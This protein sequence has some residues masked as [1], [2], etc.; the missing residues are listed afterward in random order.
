[1]ERALKAK[2]TK[3][4]V[5]I[6]VTHY[7][8]ATMAEKHTTVLAEQ[9]E[10]NDWCMKKIEQFNLDKDQVKKEL[11]EYAAKAKQDGTACFYDLDI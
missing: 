8:C 11:E 10:A 1:M 6:Y 5:E 7:T 3:A 2:I 4:V 9:K